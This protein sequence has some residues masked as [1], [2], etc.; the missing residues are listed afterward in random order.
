MFAMNAAVVDLFV[1]FFFGFLG[2]HRFRLGQV[3]WGIVYLVTF[4]LFGFGW[5]ID[6][7]RYLIAT[8]S[9]QR[10][11]AING[12]TDLVAA[13]YTPPSAQARAAYAPGTGAAGTYAPGAGGAANPYAPGAGGSTASYSTK[14]RDVHTT[15]PT[16]DIALKPGEYLSYKGQA[17][18]V[19]LQGGNDRAYFPGTLA[20]T[21]ER[22]VFTGTR[23]TLDKPLTSITSTTLFTEGI[24]LQVGGSTYTFATSD[25]PA[26]RNAIQRS[27]AG[28]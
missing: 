2:V 28:S 8:L 13:P 1:C 4:G 15:I 27:V 26:V 10:I 19:V 12:L 18:F 22:V 5:I 7:I 6:F 23:G 21:S 11:V 16:A 17:S 3:G 9:G 20:I 25:A 14:A 24:A